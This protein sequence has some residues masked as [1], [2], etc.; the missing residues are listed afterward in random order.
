MRVFASQITRK[1]ELVAPRL[2]ARFARVLHH[3]TANSLPLTSWQHRN[4]LHNTG[5][6]AVLAELL[7]DLEHISARDFAIRY[8]NQQAEA[9]P[10]ANARKV[11]ASFLQ[12]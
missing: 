3:G 12:T 9:R 10:L 7:H 1:R 4:V 8:S 2:A 5:G 11:F 6:R